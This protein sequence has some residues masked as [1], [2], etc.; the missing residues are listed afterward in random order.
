M[1]PEKQANKQLHRHNPT[2]RDRLILEHVA[3]YRLT[4]L[5]ALQRAVLPG[6]TR[7]AVNKIANRLCDAGLLRK[8][9]LLYPMNYFVPGELGV[10]S[11]GLGAHRATP[12]G[13]QSL[14]QEFALLA[15]ATLGTNS[16]L[17][18]NPVEVKRRCPWLPLSLA[19]APH[20]ID[21]ADVLELVRVDLGGPADHVARK[22]AVDLTERCRIPEFVA[23]VAARQFRL[24]VI[25]STTDKVAAIQRALNHHQWPSGLLVHFSVVRQLLSLGASANHA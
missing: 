24:V 5:E 11:L 25:T 19:M 4:T 1:K 8:H 20:C 13:S 12:L 2:D 6:L 17:R 3:R 16:H 14:P 15:F 10:R 9:K 21:Q 23:L 7:N 18:L 22:C